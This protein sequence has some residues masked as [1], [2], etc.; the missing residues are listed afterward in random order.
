MD[1][2]LNRFAADVYFQGFIIFFG[3]FEGVGD[4]VFENLE[5]ACLVAIDLWDTLVNGDS[6]L[7]AF[8]AHR[9]FLGEVRGDGNY[10]NELLFSNHPSDAAEFEQIVNIGVHALRAL[11]DSIE[12]IFDAIVSSVIK[13]SF[14]EPCE[15][16]DCEQGGFEIMGCGVYE[17]FE[18]V[19]AVFEFA[20][21]EID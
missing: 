15:A 12:E 4:E 7:A 10:I 1:V 5:E 17:L 8:E 18:F 3:V 6:D 20:C 21:G 9:H 16:L 2:I 11:G 13:I 19:V 14:H